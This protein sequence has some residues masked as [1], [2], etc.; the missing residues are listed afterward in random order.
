MYIIFTYVCLY[1]KYFYYYATTNVCISNIVI[2]FSSTSRL[3][4][5]LYIFSSALIN[6]SNITFLVNVLLIYGYL[7]NHVSRI[8]G[9][10]SYSHDKLLIWFG[11]GISYI[12]IPMCSFLIA[13]SPA[14]RLQSK[15][16]VLLYL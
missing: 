15:K 11:Y 5:Y 12:N 2:T 14:C 10:S 7:H 6:I 4:C 1:E 9:L 3:F 13:Q 8:I 16:T